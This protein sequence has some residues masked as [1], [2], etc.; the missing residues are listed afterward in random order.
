MSAEE[1]KYVNMYCIETSEVTDMDYDELPEKAGTYH[2][3]GVQ[4][5]SYCRIRYTAGNDMKRTERQRTVLSM[6]YD[7]VKDA[8]A[9][10]IYNIIKKVLPLTETSLD[11]SELVKIGTASI[12]MD[13]DSQQGFPYE[14]GYL[15]LGKKG[16]VVVPAD[17]EHNVKALHQYLFDDAEYEPSETVTDI[18]ASILR[19]T[20][21]KNK[22]DL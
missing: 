18:S 7:K 19:E 9:K 6:L 14:Y 4:A 20:G 15:N 2:L 13:L 16:D 10:Q 3:N 17:L 22:V 1:A 11:M 21:I 8:D 5:V 12:G